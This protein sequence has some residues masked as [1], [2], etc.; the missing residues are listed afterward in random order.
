[1]YCEIVGD[2]EDWFEDCL[3]KC[4]SQRTRNMDDATCCVVRDVVAPGTKVTWV[5]LFRPASL[6]LQFF[7]SLLFSFIVKIFDY[8]NHESRQH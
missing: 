3:H 8:S 7:R 6:L 5:S 2:D 1:M 4:L